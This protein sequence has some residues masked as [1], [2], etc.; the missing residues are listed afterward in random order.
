MSQ[1]LTKSENRSLTLW[2]RASRAMDTFRTKA[3]PDF[4]D[5]A[6][7]YQ[8][9]FRFNGWGWNR[10]RGK[11]D[12]KREVG[13]LDLNS[14]AM[15]VVNCTSLRIPEAIPAVVTRNKQGKEEEIDPSHPCAQL[16][17]RP[18]KH[19]VW[20][21]YAGGCSMSWWFV[22]N[23]YFFKAR[24]DFTGEVKELWYLPHHLV[25]PRWPG[26]HGNI[27]V[28]QWAAA[29]G[30]KAKDL[31]PFIS[32]YE[33]SVPGK[34]P[35]LYKAADVLHLKRGVDLSNPRLGLG[36]FEP[37][38]KDLLGDDKAAQFTAAIMTNLG[39]QVPVF[40]PKDNTGHIT[41]EQA[42]A[43][44]EGWI[45]KTTGDNAGEPVIWDYPMDIDTVGHSPKDLVVSDIRKAV[46]SR[47]CA[48]CQISPAALQLMI[49]LEN[50]TSYASSEQARQQVYEEVII[51]IQSV[52]AQTIKWQLLSEF[53]GGDK[54]DFIFDTSKVRV[55]QEDT[56]N[57]FKR[58]VQVFAAGGSTYDQFLVA[59]G[60][61]PVGA[62]LG[63][64]RL[65]PGMSNPMTPDQ[66]IGKADGSLAP[67]PAP[68]PIDPASLAKFSDIDQWQQWMED[69]MKDFKPRT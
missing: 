31:D 39:I 50:G 67:E 21:N 61:P 27:N 6:T 49:G 4:G 35:I 26:D 59:V 40:R 69:Q 65:I 38:Y 2:E 47:V 8:P 55:L 36:A 11:I 28:E 37:L 45:R 60:K 19:N 30:E 46:E 25:K 29:N 51:P 10:H 64:I 1:A 14:L 53:E 3:A 41:P 42:A 33:F 68:T 24:N 58:E 32:H 15:A 44:K 66:L 20:S 23:V 17:S 18:N 5:T 43:I 7:F 57:L 9:S 12:H 16:I 22:G 54:A 56:D 62:P 13:D 63:D 52:W 48:V 34:R